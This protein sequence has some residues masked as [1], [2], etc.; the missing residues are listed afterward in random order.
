MVRLVANELNS[1]GAEH[2]M[3]RAGAHSQVRLVCR[4]S[5]GRALRE[6]ESEPPEAGPRQRLTLGLLTTVLRSRTLYALH[7]LAPL[8]V[9]S[10]HRKYYGNRYS[11][12]THTTSPRNN[13]R[14]ISK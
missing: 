12:V 6:S 13:F 10:H 5:L 8:Y 4:L 11:G 14:E 9:E 1:A 7:C 3:H 2:G